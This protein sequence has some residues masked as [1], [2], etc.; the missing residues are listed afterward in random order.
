MTQGHL[1]ASATAPA[2]GFHQVSRRFEIL[3]SDLSR[4][5]DYEGD[6]GAAAPAA[7]RSAVLLRI[8]CTTAGFTGTFSPVK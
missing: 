6:V 7:L 8:T 3:T 2:Q 1:N 5:R 4:P